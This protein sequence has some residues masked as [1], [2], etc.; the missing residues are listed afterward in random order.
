M[1]KKLV[2]AL[3]LCGAISVA[4]LS[5]ANAA[6]VRN[7]LP[8]GRF[9][10][11][12]GVQ[13]KPDGWN[14]ATIEKAHALGFR[15]IRRGFY[16]NAVEKEKG[17][18]DFSAFDAQVARARELG[19]TVIACLFG[20]NSLYGESRG[21]ILT[22]AGR[23]GFAAFAAAA[24]R[25]YANDPIVF[26]IWN[27]PNVRTF[28]RKDGTHNSEPYADEYSALVN[29]VVPKM[30]E[31]DPS[32]VVVAGSVSNY[33]QPSYEWTEFCFRKGVLK[34]GIS[35]WSVH[36]YGVRTPEE[37]AV[38]HSVTRQLL[39]KYGASDL[40]MG[41]TERGYAAKETAT[42]EGWSGGEAAKA[43]AHQ[44]AHFVRQALIDQLCGVRFS[45]WYEWGGNEGFALFR[46]DGTEA[47]AVEALRTL[48]KELSGYRVQ[49][50]IQT[51]SAQDYLLILVNDAGARKL[52]AWTAPPPQGTPDE[53]W[54]HEIA[55]TYAG[56]KKQAIALNELP[57]YLPLSG[58]D[59]E[60]VSAVT[61]TP[62]PQP[63]AHDVTAIPPGGRPLG[64]FEAG[65]AWTFIPNTG[66]G[67]LALEK[68]ADGVSYL[69]V[70][71]DFSAS[72]SKSTPYVMATVPAAVEGAAAI[73]FAAR[74]P[75]AQQL[76]FRVTDATGQTLQWKT[77]L[78]GTGAWE[79]IRFPLDRK[80]EHWDGA[81]DGRA[82]FPLKS[83]CVSIPKPPTAVAGH[84]DYAGAVAVGDAPPDRTQAHP[85]ARAAAAAQPSATTAAT[86]EATLKLYDVRT[87]ALAYTGT[88]AN[89]SATPLPQQGA[90]Q[91]AP[92]A[93][94]AAG[95]GGSPAP[96]MAP[97]P[98]PALPA[99]TTA[100]NLFETPWH[101]AKNTG[102]GSFTLEKDAEG[103]PFGRLTYDFS[104]SKARSTPY[105]IASV[106]MAVPE[107]TAILFT[108]RGAVAGQRLTFRVVDST[109]QTLQWKGKVRNAGTWE[110]LTM[111]LNRKLE[112]WDGANDGRTHFPLKSLVISVPQPAGVSS[113]T[114]EYGA[115][116]IR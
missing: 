91:P 71:Y 45:V 114:V 34:S 100:L 73:R 64:L 4:S 61:T 87:G 60:P 75:V 31:A 46:P 79:E 37:H 69:R 111:P 93:A 42:G 80:L 18:Y 74:S 38:G 98:V 28:W 92:A 1:K 72:R 96:A 12:L 32:C 82:H 49:S 115:V 22:Q 66:K 116:S 58:Q 44:A 54:P 50:R 99:G 43:A 25:H 84:V 106:P 65:A 57:V 14:L 15:I 85:A 70:Q 6:E 53:V 86:G 104:R 94:P 110:T 62:K 27:E 63:V 56:G 11:C 48:V 19:M 88:V 81:N 103:K 97:L 2:T 90:A 55:L 68:D 76:T 9:P 23:E 35:G 20:G 26:E 51:D 113:G 89:L 112:H 21:G 30:R 95:G 16:W 59:G 5:P 108:V 40:P 47:P 3:S 102:E 78:K 107:A 8:G 101:F 33:W 17:V 77:R 67:S 52:A 36:P 41:N 29:T 109:G 7:A 105:V 39:K 13:L 10:D 83:F 24:A